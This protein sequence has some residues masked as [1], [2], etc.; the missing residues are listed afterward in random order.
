MVRAFVDRRLAPERSRRMRF[1][2]RRCGSG[3]ALQPRAPRGRAGGSGRPSRRRAA[4][5][6]RSARGSGTRTPPASTVVSAT[7]FQKGSSGASARIAS[8]TFITS[9]PRAALGGR[10][11]RLGRRLV[12][13]RRGR[14][15]APARPRSRPR[16]RPRPAVLEH[17]PQVA[18]LPA[19]DLER[20]RAA[21]V[22]RAAERRDDGVGDLAA[23]QVAGHGAAR[24]GLGDRPQQRRRVGMARGWRRSPPRAPIS[25]I[26]P[27]YMIAI[28]SQKNFAVARSWVM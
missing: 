7:P 18:R 27:R 8:N 2:H 4:R 10:Q 15:S 3:S 21:R 23:R 11:Q 1:A 16:S 17:R 14:R 13:R 19:A 20:P 24:V 22:E 28:R 9:S 12:E 26:R 6:G 25:T 5:A